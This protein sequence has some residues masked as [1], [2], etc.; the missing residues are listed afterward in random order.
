V[1]LQL[2]RPFDGFSIV[3][4]ILLQQVIAMQNIENRL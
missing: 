1:A 2:H 3:A 4:L